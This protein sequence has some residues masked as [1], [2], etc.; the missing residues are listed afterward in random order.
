VI[1]S[2]VASRL[3]IV[4]LGGMCGV[5]IFNMLTA[6]RLHRAAEPTEHPRVS[7]L[8]PARDEE[9]TLLRTL[10]HTTSTE[11]PNLEILVLD[12]GSTDRTAEVV[13]KFAEASPDVRLVRGTLLPDG[14]LGKCWACHQLSEVASGEILLFC[15]AD[16]E[17]GP[18][19]VQRTVSTMQQSG[20]GVLTA[21]P[22]QITPDPL[23]AAV[24]PLI[25]QLPVLALLPLRLIE[26]LPSPLL[27]MGNGQWLAFRRDSYARSGGHRTVKSDVV[28]D[29]AI[30]RAAK[31]SGSRLV[32]ALA[33][34][35]LAVQ[36][37]QDGR[38][39]RQ[40]FQKNLYPLSGGRPL[41][42]LLVLTVFGITMIFPLLAPFTAGGSRILPLLLI[43]LRVSGVSALGHPWRSVLLH[44]LGAILTTALALDSARATRLGSTRWKGRTIPPVEGAIHPHTSAWKQG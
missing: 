12:D 3:A 36:M 8:I 28:E 22:R 5:A 23:G 29:V 1:A 16:V 31:A 37:Y 34:D 38:A 18:L 42:F 9:D 14:W 35:D 39:L 11:Y 27:A 10:P 19:A 2:G 44:P 25:A 4:T 21:L 32:V 33:P 17:M 15:D 20:A 30:A 7:I 41:P 24:V 40:G 13:E 6:R 26:R 43:L